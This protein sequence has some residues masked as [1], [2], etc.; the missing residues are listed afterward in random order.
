MW[1]CNNFYWILMLRSSSGIRHNSRL[2]GGT[3]G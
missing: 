1:A 2:F 3:V